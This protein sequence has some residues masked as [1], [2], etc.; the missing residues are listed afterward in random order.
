ML[1]NPFMRDLIQHD[2]I[3]RHLQDDEVV[4]YFINFLK[5]LVL[6]LDHETVNFFFNDRIKTFPLYQAAINLYHCK[7]QLVRTGVRTIT[8][9]IFEI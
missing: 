2:F 1:S 6:K 3:T 8:L 7:E 9:T 5:A 4:D